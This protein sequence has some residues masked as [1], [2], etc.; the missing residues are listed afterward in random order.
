MYGA[1]MGVKRFDK[2]VNFLMRSEEYEMLEALAHREGLTASDIV[3]Q[4]VRRAHVA[5]FGEPP[6]PMPKAKGK[7][8]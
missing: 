3:R 1:R 4:L 5:K 2:R 8:R 6:V 7:K